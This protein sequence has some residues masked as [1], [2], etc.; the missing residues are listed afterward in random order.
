MKRFLALSL[1]LFYI[2]HGSALAQ[3][4]TE[5]LVP[6]TLAG[7][8]VISAEECDRL[9]KENVRV[10]D[11][12]DELEYE[13]GHI[14]GALNIHYR[15]K[16]SK[17]IGFDPS[18]DKFDIKRLPADKLAPMIIYCNGE[19]CWKSFKASTAAV[20]AGYKKV[21]W[22]RGGMPEWEEKGFPS[23]R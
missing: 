17:S 9:L 18:V 14:P 8:T 6:P 16:S 22:L 15:E 7:A 5:E 11:V 3:S 2:A 12:R 19:T 10:I 21:F 20:K 4:R 13:A 1:T 23:E